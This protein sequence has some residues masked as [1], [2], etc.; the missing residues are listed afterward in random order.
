[1]LRHTVD[2]TFTLIIY[3]CYITYTSHCRRSRIQKQP[4]EMFLKTPVLEFLFYKVASLQPSN[5]VKK[6]LLHRC[7]PM[8]YDKFLKTPILKNFCERLFLCI[9]YIDLYNSLQ[10]TFFIFTNNF[11][12]IMQLKP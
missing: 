3:T 6:R 7:F 4:L 1:M 5:V 11:F 10:Y 12:F 9:S 2:H 8:K